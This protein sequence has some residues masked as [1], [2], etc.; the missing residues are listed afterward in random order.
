MDTGSPIGIR[1]RQPMNAALNA[2][3][4]GG[5]P[6]GLPDIGKLKRSGWNRSMRP[7]GIRATPKTKGNGT[8]AG[9]KNTRSGMDTG[10]NFG[11]GSGTDPAGTGNGLL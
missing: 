1:G 3:I 10:K 6:N 4:R 11:C 8:A 5:M 7:G 9:M 2:R